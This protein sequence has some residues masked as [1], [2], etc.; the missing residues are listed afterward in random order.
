MPNPEK[1]SESADQAKAK[2]APMK[3]PEAAVFDKIMQK[4]GID[5]NQ[6]KPE[7]RAEFMKI[8]A[9][10][11]FAH[12]EKL[13]EDPRIY[14]LAAR[15]LETWG[16][17]KTDIHRSDM[18]L[19]TEQDKEAAR[20][21]ELLRRGNMPTE[22]YSSNVGIHQ[23]TTEIK[24]GKL[25]YKKTVT[26]TAVSQIENF[27]RI[28]GDTPEMGTEVGMLRALYHDY[29]RQ[30]VD[31]DKV[32]ENIN[33]LGLTEYFE[34]QMEGGK[35]VT[36]SE[37]IDD[38]RSGAMLSD[39]LRLQAESPFLA[40]LDVG[41][42]LAVATQMVEY[43]HQNSNRGIGE[44]LGEDV[45]IQVKDGKIVG[46]RLALP[47]MKYEDNVEEVTQKAYDLLDFCFSVGTA[48][49]QKGGQ[50]QAE[51]NIRTVLSNYKDP[52]VKAKVKELAHQALPEQSMHNNA[53]LGFDRVEN[54][55]KAYGIIRGLVLQYLG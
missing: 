4:T 52:I 36:I 35:V 10:V 5:P 16:Y 7:H 50:I 53:R 55:E 28:V 31:M 51:F 30:K 46:A 43:V 17:K 40:G 2:E 24:D 38:V 54:K 15:Q 21:M 27:L 45:V 39:L 22:K 3:G 42:A 49:M 48:G 26:D 1:S 11:D 37:K 29:V 18:V 6:I 23:F 12:P 9:G 19:D 20:L 44:L 41:D 32:A 33:A 47:D 8:L 25:V 14:D 34:S 13:D